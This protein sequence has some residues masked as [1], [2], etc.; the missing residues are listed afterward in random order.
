MNVDTMNL[1]KKTSLLAIAGAT[2]AWNIY[3]RFEAAEPN[4][5]LLVIR[6]GELRKCGVGI[7][8]FRG[9]NEVVVKF[10]SLLNKVTFSAQQVSKEMQGVEL[11]GFVIWVIKRDGNYPLKAYKHIRNL[12]N[13][14]L[15]SEVNTHI[16][17]MAESI[18]RAQIANL[19]IHEVVAQ[20]KKVRSSIISEMQELLSG[21]GIWLETVEV[22][23]VKI[24]S[25]TLFN[26][27]Q[28]PFRSETQ[29]TAEQI[30]IT[31][32]NQLQEERVLAQAKM[33]KIRNEKD[34]ETQ[35]MKSQLRLKQEQQEQKVIE[36]REK[37]KRNNIELKKQTAILQTES[38]AEIQAKKQD[39]EA[40]QLKHKLN[41]AS[42][43]HEAELKKIE[44]GY[45]VDQSMGDINVKKMIL[46]TV[47]NIYRSM[48][49]DSM[50]IVNFGP[51]QGL[52]HG[53][54]K[55]AMAIKEVQ[56]Q[57]SD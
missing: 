2:A 50:K 42:M 34:T 17:S 53:I 29:K 23:E 47:E 13:L 45:K 5:W 25:R 9:I 51:N 55:M 6:D 18:V 38:D 43:K 24:L 32:E 15:D 8:V 52:E 41:I 22:T 20:R 21:W 57:L 10:P 1:V 11:S 16:K 44:T 56:S 37:I 48:S 14:Q 4:E 30:R 3:H 49:V 54:G 35:I 7:S 26:D 19:S 28:Q 12:A 33:N 31:T 36:E 39:I 40:A 27:L 46:K